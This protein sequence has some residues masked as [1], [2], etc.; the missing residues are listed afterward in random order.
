MEKTLIIIFAVGVT[1]NLTVLAGCKKTDPGTPGKNEVFLQY[2]TFNP[3][4]LKV[5]V[6]TTVTFINKDNANHTATANSKLFDSGK[7]TS[8]NS[9]S[10]TF[11]TA[12]TFYFYCNYHSSVSQEQGVILVQ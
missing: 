1:F 12:G 5:Q 3:T 2:K 10:F 4:Q 7:I 8:G 11:N 9:Y 6:G